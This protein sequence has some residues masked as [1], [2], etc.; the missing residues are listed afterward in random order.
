[1]KALS[2]IIDGAKVMAFGYD[3]IVDKKRRKAPSTVT[4]S[5]DQ[6]LKGSDRR[7]AIATPREQRR[8]N[9]LAAWA[10]RKHLDYVSHFTFQAQTSSK[11][12]NQQLESLVRWWSR[13]KNCDI[14][15]RHSLRKYTRLVEASRTVDGDIGVMRLRSGH[16]QAIEGDRIAT[17][18]S[19]TI[20]TDKMRLKDQKNLQNGV[21]LNNAGAARS[22]V[23]LKRKNNSKTLEFDRIVRATNMDLVA[24]YDRFD[25]V[26]GI[27]PLMTALDTFADILEVQEYQRIKQKISSLFGT[28]IKR[29]LTDDNDGFNYTDDG[30]DT[31]GNN[32][33]YDYELKTGMKLELDINDDL[34]LVESKTPGGSFIDFQTMCIHL[35]LLAL[36]MPMTMFDSRQSSYSAQRQD[37]LNYQR[38]SKNKQEDLQE[39]LDTLV[40]WKLRQWIAQG[41]IGP[42]PGS[43]AGNINAPVG[44]AQNW[45]WR[46][47]GV[48]WIDP[49][50]EITAYNAGISSGL[51]SRKEAKS[52]MGCTD[53]T[54]DQTFD[55]LAEEE[56]SAVERGITIQVAMPGAITT[57]DEEGT[58]NDANETSQD[59]AI[60]DE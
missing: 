44:T 56:E 20:P 48:P 47:C 49:L 27:S 46:P 13:P 39:F 25:Q 38:S 1:M 2:N 52:L 17:P 5:E 15:G 57:R 12:Y 37:I 35:A 34:D 3:G 58:R 11:E 41:L 55:E 8:N 50:K 28:V 21:L 19:G 51:L 59:R 23:V 36:D 43:A 32:P 6:I 60:E 14:A 24:Y 9:V 33:R 10:I 7:K 4:A 30:S 16:I 26:R 22:Y 40:A 18:T 31:T 29:N 42:P 45:I 54:I 53:Q